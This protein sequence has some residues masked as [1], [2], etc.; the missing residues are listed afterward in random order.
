MDKK[1]REE[2]RASASQFGDL[3]YTVMNVIGKKCFE[4]HRLL[5]V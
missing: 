5:V 4:F 3:V 2:Y 1:Q